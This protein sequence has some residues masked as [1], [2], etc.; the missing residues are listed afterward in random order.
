MERLNQMED[1]SMYNRSE[2]GPGLP[3]LPPDAE[4]SELYKIVMRHSQYPPILQT[5]TWTQ[6]VPF[7]EQ[8][9]HRTPSERIGNNYSPHVQDLKLSSLKQRKHNVRRSSVRPEVVSSTSPGR[10]QTVK[11]KRDS[12]FSPRLEEFSPPISRPISPQEQMDIMD[13]EEKLKASNP[14][15]TKADI[16]R[17]YHYITEGVPSSVLTP[18]P[19]QQMMNIQR[20]LPDTGDS[21]EKIQIMKANLEKEVKR[22]YEFSL[23]MSIVDYILMDPSE[24]ERLSIVSI[25]KPFARRVIRAPVPWADSYR[26][27]HTWLNK[28]L[29]TI[30]P[31]MIFL[32]DA[33]INNFSSLRFV[34]LEDLCCASLPL[35]P[36]EFEEFIQK[37]CQRTRDELVQKWLPQCVSVIY[38]YMKESKQ[39]LPVTAHE[40]FSCVAALMSLH[41]RSLVIES[42]QDVLY[43]FSI[44]K[45]G[46]NF[47]DVYDELQYFQD[48]VL[49]IKLQVNEPNIDFNPSFQECWELIH[50]VFLEIIKSAKNLPRVDWDLYPG[51]ENLYL[52]TVSPD[53]PVVRD[54]INKA[55]DV[56][57]ENTVGPPKYLSV[58]KKYTNLL[59]NTAKQDITA[60][61]K[62]KHSLEGFTKK[63][64]SVA[65]LWKE[66]ASLPITVP[67]SMFCL[68]TEKLNEDLCARTDQLKDQIV[69]FI[70]EENRELNRRICQKYEDITLTIRSTPESTEEMMSLNHYIRETSEVTIYKLID[71][72][73]EAVERLNFLMQH[74]ILTTDDMRLNSSVFQWPTLI[75]TELE[76]SKTRVATMREQAEDHLQTRVSHL[77]ERLKDVENELQAFKKEEYTVIDAESMENNVENLWRI[78]ANL[79]AAVIELEAINKEQSLL[80]RDPSEFPSLQIL[81]DDKQPYEQLWTTALKFQ[82]MSEVWLNGPFRDLDAEKISK[83]IDTMRRTIYELTKSLSNL[84]GP[85]HVAETVKQRIDQFKQYLPVLS[86]VCNPGL[87]DQHWEMIS[88]IVGVPVRPDVNSSLQDMLDLGLSKFSDQLEEIGASASKEYSQEK[89]IGKMEN[90]C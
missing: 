71:E 69:M 41:L 65:L 50:R 36:S 55:K 48:Q 61:L 82:S 1:D 64:E 84:P 37:Q 25:P 42:L 63:I 79:D 33:W 59:D 23:K 58:Y 60:F 47:G 28:H 86:T 77:D 24:R 75:L 38:T 32:Q 3:P 29:F 78:S 90:E 22:D 73:D 5:N 74:A 85:C 83:E 80:E 19:P 7:K 12:T 21:N 87:K 54:I 56:F 44:H 26:E 57:H 20:L 51:T 9:Y 11:A 89:S 72:T 15:P 14:K 46:N 62:E 35:L 16:D 18:L 66:I 43:F 13:R 70:V 88:S 67:L 6:A 34:R 2:K 8:R 10:G 49:L 81:I 4:P 30:N 17:Y 53:E 40:F 68:Y 45:E 52:R 76:L 39:G 31:I 27:V